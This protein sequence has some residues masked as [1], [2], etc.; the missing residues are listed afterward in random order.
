M[1]R[2]TKMVGG[3]KQLAA[4]SAAERAVFEADYE[5][6]MRRLDLEQPSLRQLRREMGWRVD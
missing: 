5:A 2:A 3:K 1:I 6:E 4:M